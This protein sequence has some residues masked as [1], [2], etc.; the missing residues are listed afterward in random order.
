MLLYVFVVNNRYKKRLQ[1]NR[2]FESIFRENH[3]QK[4]KEMVI[5]WL[6]NVKVLLP[7]QLFTEKADIPDIVFAFSRV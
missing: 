1:I 4:I 6:S 7:F 2:K 5:H 3:R